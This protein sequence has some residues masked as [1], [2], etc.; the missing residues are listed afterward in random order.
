MEAERLLNNAF[1]DVKKLLS[2]NMNCLEKLAEM[3]ISN[4]RM[5]GDEIRLV[6]E[7]LAHPD[8]LAVREETKEVAF[9]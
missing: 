5:S 6:V 7:D 3:L 4:D 1:A 8:D 2:R 9:L